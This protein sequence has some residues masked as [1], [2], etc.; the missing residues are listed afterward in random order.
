MACD[1][2]P[3]ARSLAAITGKTLAIDIDGDQGTPLGDA[4]ASQLARTLPS[5]L[6]VLVLKG[7]LLVLTVQTTK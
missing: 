7:R 2:S 5:H 6:K 1:V 4:G 3:V